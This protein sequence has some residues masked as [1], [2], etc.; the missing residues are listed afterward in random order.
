MSMKTT[1]EKWG[2]FEAAFSGRQDGNPFVDYEIKGEFT[3]ADETKCVDGFY[4][5]EGIY[6]I[7]FMPSFEGEY[8]Y[9]VWGTFSDCVQ[10]GDFTVTP[11]REG[12]HG[13]VR[14]ANT[15]HFAYEDGTPYY[16]IGTTCYVWALQTEELQEQTLK[17]LKDSAFNK[18]RFCIFPKHYDYNL[19]EPYSYPYEGTPMDSSVLTPE[20]FWDYNGRAEGND[21]DYKRFNPIHF[22]HLEKRIQ[23][24]RDLGIEAD[25]IVMHPYDRWGFSMMTKEEDDLYW[26]YVV[27]RFSAYRNVWWSLANEYDLMPQK[28]LAD[29][30]RYASILCEK[31]V[32]SHLRSIHN[33]KKM[34]DFRRPWVTHCSIQRVDSYMSGECV[35]EWRQRFQ[36]PVVLDEIVYEGNIE[37]NWGNISGEEMTRRFWEAAVR[38]GYPGH[39]ETYYSEDRILW[40]SHG[41]V[42]KGTSPERFKFLLKILQETPGHGLKLN[43]NRVMMREDIEATVDSLIPI[44]YYLFYYSYR[45]PVFKEF[46]FD[47]GKEYEV[48]VID[49]WEMT[50]TKCGIFKGRFKIP[51]PGKEYMAIRIYEK[52][53]L[54]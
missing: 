1:V 30:E 2:I 4:D 47:D 11:A 50:I 35:D 10:E 24:L 16:S 21:W 27:A 13:P 5:G 26:N 44:P 3:G 51:L 15:F 9:R 40:W 48:E 19:N 8:H 39:G 41:G 31:D 29:W 34:Y 33:C 46:N 36:K 45:R 28:S 6:K 54:G 7:R 43:P 42:L 17:T 37:H 53:L 25:L 22:S 18:I 14:V 20:N 12:N 52:G 23:D 32:Y 38:G 49:T